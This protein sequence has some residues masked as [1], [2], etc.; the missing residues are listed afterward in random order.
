MARSRG[1]AGLDLGPLVEEVG[2]EKYLAAVKVGDVIETFGA[3]KLVRE[4]GVE[5]FLASLSAEERKALREQ[6]K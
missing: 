2:L 4:I 5:R 1:K 6:L 3:K